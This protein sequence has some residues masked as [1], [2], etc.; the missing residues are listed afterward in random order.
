M[1][2]VAEVS[3]VWSEGLVE[4]GIAPVW[5]AAFFISL[6]YFIFWNGRTQSFD[7]A[8]AVIVA[9]MSVCFIANF[10][11]LMPPPMDIV[12]GL[13]PSLPEVPLDAG[14]GPFLVIASM[15]GTTVFSGLF[16]IRTTLVKEAGWTLADSDK[17]R[18]DALV[19][20]VMMFVISGSIMAAA[21][22]TLHAEG[23][24]LDKASQMI[25]LLEPLAGSLATTVFVVGIVAAGVSSQ[26]PN[27]LM[28][29]WLLC[30]FGESSR[31]MTLPRYRLMVLV[32]SLLGLVVPIFEARPV[33]VM[34]VSQAFNA[35]IL[36][37]T[38]ACILYLGNR[39]DLMGEHRNT[40]STNAVLAAILLFSLVTTSMGIRGVW[41]LLQSG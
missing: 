25:G 27:V 8:L 6:V 33:L 34:I 20:V 35:V 37:V 26:F 41:Q 1:G 22:G 15:V 3:S 30:D 14:R 16:I 12:K 28:L 32:I 38:V 4:G 29:P 21:A 18:N 7:R 36:P 11:L 2:I 9:V 17:Q 40:L 23:L 5:F 24:G 31:D 19:A 10:F 39:R 13:V